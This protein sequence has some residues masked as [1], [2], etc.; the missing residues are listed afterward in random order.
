MT[1][2]S[3]ILTADSIWRTHRY[4]ITKRCGNGVVAGRLLNYE[5]AIHQSHRVQGAQTTRPVIGEWENGQGRIFPDEPARMNPTEWLRRLRAV[6]RLE[7]DKRLAR[8]TDEIPRI[9]VALEGWSPSDLGI[10]CNQG[11]FVGFSAHAPLWRIYGLIPQED[12]NGELPVFDGQV[13]ELGRFGAIY[14]LVIP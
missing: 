9:K 12:Y 13:R 1:I 11:W 8:H 10:F 3:A 14:K 2:E 7:W 6:P 5:L 4:V